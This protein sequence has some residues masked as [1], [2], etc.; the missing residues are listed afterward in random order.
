K[1]TPLSRTSAIAGAVSG[2][3]FSARN[4]SGTNRMRLWGVAFSADAAPEASVKRLADSSSMT[5]RMGV[6]LENAGVS[7]ELLGLSRFSMQRICYSGRSFDQSTNQP[8]RGASASE[9]LAKPPRKRREGAASAGC[10]VHPRVPSLWSPWSV[11][12]ARHHLAV[13]D[14][15]V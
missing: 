5:R 14:F 4:P 1:L 7:A 3:T 8:S 6:S 15:G 12:H 13:K 11:P 9:S 2:V 10:L